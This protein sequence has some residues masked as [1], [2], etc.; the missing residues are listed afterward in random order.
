MKIKDRRPNDLLLNVPQDYVAEL[1][2]KARI[3]LAGTSHYPESIRITVLLSRCKG[4]TFSLISNIFRRVA[5]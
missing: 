1:L 2:Q 3:K 5:G 4:K